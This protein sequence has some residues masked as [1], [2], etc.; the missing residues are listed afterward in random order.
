VTLDHKRRTSLAFPARHCPA[1]RDRIPDSFAIR[2]RDH[3]R[4]DRFSLA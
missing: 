4:P 2:P 3:T 1:V